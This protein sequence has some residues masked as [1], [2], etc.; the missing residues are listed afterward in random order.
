MVDEGIYFI[1]F[2]F[3]WIRKTGTY[4]FWKWLM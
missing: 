4:D 1:L 3:H 2:H